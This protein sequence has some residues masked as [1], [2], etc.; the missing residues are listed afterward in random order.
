MREGGDGEENKDIDVDYDT[1]YDE[2][3]NDEED[4]VGI[5]YPYAAVVGLH[6]KL[7]QVMKALNGDL[8]RWANRCHEASLQLVRSGVFPK[9]RVARGW[10][11]GVRSQHSWV[12]VGDDCYAADALIVDPTMRLNEVWF[13]CALD[14]LHH[15]HGNGSIWTWGRPL[16]STGAPVELTPVEP[17]SPAAFAFLKMLGP[18]DLAGWR[19]LANAPVGGWP[20]AE[21]FEAMA[22]TDD[23][24][25]FIPIDILGMLT[26]RNPSG[27]YR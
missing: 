11:K 10:C 3:E 8:S 21:I 14:D 5:E 1:G 18:L 19:A 24:K 25:A 13:G 16:Q 7:P 6:E 26:N 27:L 23:L 17:F 4:E 15:P 2:E 22:D 9:A 12:V 20:S